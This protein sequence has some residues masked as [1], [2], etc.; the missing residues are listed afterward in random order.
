MCCNEPWSCKQCS[1]YVPAGWWHVCGR[2]EDGHPFNDPPFFNPETSPPYV[3]FA[4]PLFDFLQK[5]P[6]GPIC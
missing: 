3:M 4:G 2:P 5:P 6:Y 1:Q